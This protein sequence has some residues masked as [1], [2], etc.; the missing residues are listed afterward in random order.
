MFQQ[1][2]WV[3]R[4]HADYGEFAA[5]NDHFIKHGNSAFAPLIGE[6]WTIIP[7]DL[8]PPVHT[9]FRAALNP[10]FSPSRMMALDGRIRERGEISDRT[11]QGSW[12]VRVHPRTSRSTFQS[13]SSS[14]CSVCRRT[15]CCNST[16]WEQRLIHGTDVDMRT[17]SLRAIKA[18]LL[19]TI[20][21]RKAESGE[22]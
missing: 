13:R 19:E 8:D 10:V 11:F 6:D 7:A 14:T 20:A 21:A 22:D 4:R 3:V 2:G 18:L 9:A 15:G 16:Q 12:A 17:S 5:D 1:P